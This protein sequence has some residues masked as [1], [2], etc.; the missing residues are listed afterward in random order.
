MGGGTPLLLHLAKHSRPALVTLPVGEGGSGRVLLVDGSSLEAHLLSSLGAGVSPAALYGAACAYVQR[1]QATGLKLVV[2]VSAPAC[3]VGQEALCCAAARAEALAGASASP[4]C[5]WA[6]GVAFRDCGC[7]VHVAAAS[8]P[9]LL[10][11]YARRFS[12]TLFALLS[13]DADFFVL[14]VRPQSATR[15]RSLDPSCRGG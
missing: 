8:L 2:C 12:S 15:R 7:E 10:L 6:L 14:G 1:L 13:D 4:A 5:S 11:G 3:A 9:R